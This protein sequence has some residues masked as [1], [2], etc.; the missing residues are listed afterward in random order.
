[1]KKLL[2][3]ICILVCCNNTFGQ[4]GKEEKVE[5][6]KNVKL[7]VKTV[8][9]FRSD[10]QYLNG[11]WV[12]GK[13]Y[14]MSVSKLNKS[15]FAAEEINYNKR[16]TVENWTKYQLDKRGNFEVV[17]NLN[18]DGSINSKT[19]I[20]NDYDSLGRF[21]GRYFM[22]ADSTIA[23]FTWFFYDSL[24]NMTQSD[25]YMQYAKSILDSYE[26][27]QYDANGRTIKIEY[28]DNAG[29]YNS[30]EAYKYDTTGK[31]IEKVDDNITVYKYGPNGLLLSAIVYNGSN[32]PVVTY[33]FTYEYFQ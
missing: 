33:R 4:F 3:L 32:T 13:E 2:S 9:T 6:E 15:G 11:N 27:Y 28:Y 22:R 16:G 24:G 21:K 31:K 25:N 12:P 26:V 10:Y 30:R 14:K 19:K 18:S 29:N 5:R 1:M 20:T 7:K 8:T 17:T 23:S